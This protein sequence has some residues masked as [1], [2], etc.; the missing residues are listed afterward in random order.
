[1]VVGKITK[2]R[3]VAG[4][5]RP[6]GSYREAIAADAA[7]RQVVEEAGI[8]IKTLTRAVKT[9]AP[10]A[11][12]RGPVYVRTVLKPGHKDHR[13]DIAQRNSQ[14]ATTYYDRVFWLDCCKIYF[15]VNNY[16]G[17]VPGGSKAKVIS[18]ARARYSSNRGGHCIRFYAVVNSLVGPVVMV[19][20]TGTT[21]MKSKFKV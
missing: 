13:L 12:V 15:N 20:V 18:D 21:G 19:P 6:Y 9:R 10:G 17:L 7:I 5:R 3:V 2:G 14:R 8:S 11:V 4:Q 16:K 1:M